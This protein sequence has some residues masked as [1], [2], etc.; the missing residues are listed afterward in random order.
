MDKKLTAEERELKKLNK[1]ALEL[2]GTYNSQDIDDILME[3]DLVI[4]GKGFLEL[5]KDLDIDSLEYAIA[6]MENK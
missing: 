4:I 1:K 5:R 2:F 6:I 3:K